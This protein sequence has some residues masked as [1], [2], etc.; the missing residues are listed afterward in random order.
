M[1]ASKTEADEIIAQY[2]AL[3]EAEYQRKVAAQ[4]GG[5]G[6]TSFDLDSKTNIDIARLTREFQQNKDI[7]SDMLV[8]LV[9]EVKIE[10]PK[11]RETTV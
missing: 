10:A 7:V 8:S 6:G 9:T 11:S 3:M 1:K 4:S 2:R 5:H